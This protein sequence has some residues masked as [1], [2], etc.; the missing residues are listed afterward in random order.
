M[1]NA[2]VLES[3]PPGFFSRH[4]LKF[5]ENRLPRRFKRLIYVS[6]VLGMMEQAKDPDMVF[7]SKLNETFKLAQRPDAYAFPMYIRSVIWKGA[8]NTAIHL[9]NDEELAIGDVIKRELNSYDCAVIGAYFAKHSPAWLRYGSLELMVNDIVLLIQQIQNFKVQSV[10][11][12]TPEH[13]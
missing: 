4:F 7:V 2:T 5:L 12:I 1:K 11:M 6:S 10:T 13:S 8:A 9:S 3:K